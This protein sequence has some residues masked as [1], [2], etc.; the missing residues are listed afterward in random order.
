MKEIMKIAKNFGTPWGIESVAEDKASKQRCVDI[1]VKKAKSKDHVFYSFFE[2]GYK[3]PKN[4]HSDIDNAIND[5]LMTFL[6]LYPEGNYD[7]GELPDGFV[8]QVHI[9]KQI[10]G[11]GDSKSFLDKI[12]NVT[13]SQKC[14]NLVKPLTQVVHLP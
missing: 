10:G 6:S 11:N 9:H 5:E 13:E 2:S 7:K 14:P 8:G 1:C 3:V 12:K 4:F